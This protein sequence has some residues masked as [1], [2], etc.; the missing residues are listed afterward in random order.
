MLP[1]LSVIRLSICKTGLPVARYQLSHCHQTPASQ[2]HGKIAETLNISTH[3]HTQSMAGSKS[4]GW[5]QRSNLAAKDLVLHEVITHPLK[6]ACWLFYY[7]ITCS[8]HNSNAITCS[9]VIWNKCIQ[10]SGQMMRSFSING[11]EARDKA[12]DKNSPT[13][14]KQAPYVA[15]ALGACRSGLPCGAF[16]F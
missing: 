16:F 10:P 1:V 11:E 12:R 7:S 4:W 13:D 6:I 15:C 14:L 9:R 3:R 2:M 5:L 8:T